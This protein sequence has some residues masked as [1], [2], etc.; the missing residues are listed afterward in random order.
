MNN[1]TTNGNLIV[2]GNLRVDNEVSLNSI[3]DISSL[4]V[5][6]ISTLNSDLILNNGDISLNNNLKVGGTSN[7]RGTVN[8]EGSLNVNDS[9]YTYT[10]TTINSINLDVSDNIIKINVKDISTNQTTDLPSGIMIQDS[11]TNIFFGYSG[12]KTD[13][14]HKDKFIITKTYYDESLQSD[15]SLSFDKPVDVFMNGSLD[16]SGGIKVA[17]TLEVSGNVK[18]DGSLESASMIGFAYSVVGETNDL[19]AGEYPFSYGAGAYDQ[20]IYF[21]YPILIKSNL[22][23]VGLLL[24]DSSMASL[25]SSIDYVTFTINDVDIT[26]NW[27]DLSGYC[28][29]NTIVYPTKNTNISYNEGDLISIKCKELVLNN[30]PSRY[31]IVAVEKARIV[32][33]FLTT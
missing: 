1:V 15:L 3:V 8:I 31:D 23:K 29:K 19:S 5:T 21:G 27:D 14:A 13:Q 12:K 28:Q 25:D 7:F 26:F 9:S 20:D 11:S 2:E 24:S 33:K 22:V 18:I 32:M 6:G 30:F 10:I 17:N 16:I 4:N